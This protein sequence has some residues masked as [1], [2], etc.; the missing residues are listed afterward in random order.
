MRFKTKPLEKLDKKEWMKKDSLKSGKLK[1][2]IG[3]R[4]P[5]KQQLKSCW[6]DLFIEVYFDIFKR[7]CRFSSFDMSMV[8]F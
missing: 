5:N 7:S 4:Q 1:L 8:Y 6:R 3:F 2:F